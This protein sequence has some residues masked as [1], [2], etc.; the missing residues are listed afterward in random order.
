M[1]NSVFVMV[2]V[3]RRPAKWPAIP[4]ED[5]KRRRNPVVQRA[6]EGHAGHAIPAWRVADDGIT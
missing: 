2:S 4:G 5:G 6:F 1:L 3:T